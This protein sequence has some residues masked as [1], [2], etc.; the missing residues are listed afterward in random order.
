MSSD[1]GVARRRRSRLPTALL[2]AVLVVGLLTVWAGI[3]MLNA[4]GTLLL[5]QCVD[6]SLAHCPTGFFTG[7]RGR[8]H[9]FWTSVTAAGAVATVAAS[10]PLITRAIRRVRSNRS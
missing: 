5:V 4:P 10:T 6:P 2:L 3:V 8:E 1:D 9:I 7:I